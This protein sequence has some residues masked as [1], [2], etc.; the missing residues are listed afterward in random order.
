MISLPYAHTSG[1]Q[2]H[3]RAVLSITVVDYHVIFQPIRVSVTKTG[4]V[5]HGAPV[6]DVI[7][8][9]VRDGRHRA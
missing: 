5:L 3:E 6:E 8:N 9:V 4:G 1:F 2:L 7:G